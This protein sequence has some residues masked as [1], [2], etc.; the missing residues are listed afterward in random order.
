MSS[1]D[2]HA[3]LSLFAG[4]PGQFDLVIVDDIMP[5]MKGTD[6]ITRMLKI[7]DD[8]PAVLMTG[9]GVIIPLEKARSSGA[10]G[11][12]AKPV[13]KEELKA[14]LDRVLTSK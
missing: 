8:V 1:T 4:F 9:R 10:R 5:T 6:L 3:A 12:L 13:L 14:V 11:V 2:P 7:K